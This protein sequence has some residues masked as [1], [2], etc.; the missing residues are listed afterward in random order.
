M[1]HMTSLEGYDKLWA[2]LPSYAL[3][4][5]WTE[6]LRNPT[7]PEATAGR[8]HVLPRQLAQGSIIG[9]YLHRR[10]SRSGASYNFREFGIKAQSP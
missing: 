1:G 5:E 9:L 8:L 10:R 2:C 7:L 4:E 6:R 3:P